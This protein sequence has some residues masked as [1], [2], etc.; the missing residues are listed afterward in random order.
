MTNNQHGI[1]LKPNQGDAY[2]LLGDSYTIKATS[3]DTLGA[4]ALL[5]IILQPQGGAP[6]HIHEHENESFYILEGEI[7]FQIENEVMIGTPGSFIHLPKGKLHS[8]A[9]KTTTP[10]KTLAWITP[11]GLEKFIAEA[12]TKVDNN[13]PSPPTLTPSDIENLL[14]V[15]PNYG[16]KFLV[17]SSQ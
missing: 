2:W 13:L 10:A 6:L 1:C 9:N 7:E 8:F 11:G 15:A 3:E 5:E 14:G 17:P 4:Y 16:V 12:G